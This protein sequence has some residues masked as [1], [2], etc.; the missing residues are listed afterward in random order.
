[1][2]YEL[3]FFH[4]KILLSISLTEIVC[5]QR[6]NTSQNLSKFKY[7]YKV[8]RTVTRQINSISTVG[9]FSKNT[10]RGHQSFLIDRFTLTIK[11]NLNLNYQFTGNEKYLKNE[12]LN[13]IY[14]LF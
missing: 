2:G 1:M 14:S 6:L 3:S 9:E 10:P 12:I 13:I 8:I 5:R 11:L 4:E 7:R